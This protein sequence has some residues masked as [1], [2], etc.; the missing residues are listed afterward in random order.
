MVCDSD[1]TLWTL[2]LIAAGA[3]AGA[4]ADDDELDVAELETETSGVAVKI[5][6]TISSSGRVAIKL[7]LLGSRWLAVVVFASES[8]ACVCKGAATAEE[9][10]APD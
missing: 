1:D 5:F 8:K 2:L 6:E 7:T 3:G 4:G 10:L 9:A